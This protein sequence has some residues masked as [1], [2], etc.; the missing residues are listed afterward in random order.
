MK[1]QLLFLK[2]LVCFFLTCPLFSETVSNRLNS[3]ESGSCIIYELPQSVI[4]ITVTK[5]DTHQVSLEAVTA[6][7]DVLN[8]EN[9]ASYLAWC[10]AGMPSASFRDELTFSLPD[11]KLAKT[12]STVHNE[13]L[14]TLLQLSM[15]K[16]PSASR[17]RA[18]PTP[19]P[20]ETDLRPVWQPRILVGGKRLDTIST[21]YSVHWPED[22]TSLANKEIILYFPDS[23]EAVSG[24]PYWIESPSSQY[25]VYVVDSEKKGEAG[26]L[27]LI[28]I[29]SNSA[30]Y[31]F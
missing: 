21:A 17:K 6:T 13:W 29:R 18:G 4:A 7:K 9:M 20:G 30:V 11:G 10:H 24:L 26:S 28:T 25:K 27:P 8:R 16:V 12:S 19:M 1:S 15:E 14:L 3:L 22:G 5:K 23:K 31:S 2:I